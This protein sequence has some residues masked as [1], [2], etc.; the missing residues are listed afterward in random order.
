MPVGFNTVAVVDF[1]DK[2]LKLYEQHGD[3]DQ[4][5]GDVNHLTTLVELSR[6]SRGASTLAAGFACQPFSRLGDERG[7]SD[8]RAMCLRGILACAFYLQV[9]AVV[10]ECVQ[11]AALNSFVTSEI[12]AFQKATGFHCAQQIYHLQDVW[13]SRRSRAWWLLTSPMLGKISLDVWPKIPFVTTVRHVI[14]SIQPWDCDDEDDLAL[15]D[16]EK[17]AFGVGSNNVS[18]FMLNFESCAPCALHSWGSQMHAC[19]CGC[20]LAGLSEH[21]L[22]DKG[23]FG[24]LVHSC[25]TETKESLIRHVHPNEVMMLCGFDPIID[26]GSSTRLTLAAAGQMASPIQTA[27]VFATLEEKIQ[28]IRGFSPTFKAEAQLHAFLTWLVMRGRQVWPCPKESILDFNAVSL[29]RFWGQVSH[30]S[31]H[32][33]MHPNRWPDLAQPV[34]IA[35]VLDLLIRQQQAL[36]GLSLPLQSNVDVPMTIQDDEDE[37]YE[38]TPWFETP[39]TGDA[40]FA[41]L[42]DACVVVFHHSHVEP[43][44]IQVSADVTVSQLIHAHEK[45][46]GPFQV[47]EVR[48][49]AGSVLPQS[50]ILKEG[51]VLHIRCTEGL[52]PPCV[53]VPASANDC[54]P[55]GLADAGP[56]G[57]VEPESCVPAPD[58]QVPGQ[59]CVGMVSPT[60]MWTVPAHETPLKPPDMKESLVEV[61]DAASVIS[62]AP[63][64]ALT[65]QQLLKLRVPSVVVNKHLSALRSQ[66]LSAEDRKAIL[67]KQDG[68]WADDEMSHHIELLLQMYHDKSVAS[69]EVPQ[70]QYMMLDPLLLTGWV[71]YG[72]S[73]CHAWARSH[74]EV[75]TAQVTVLSACLLQGHWIPVVLS[76][77][78]ETLNFHTWDAPTHLHDPL[79]AVVE[80]LGKCLGFHRVDTLRQQR[81]F[82]STDKCGA[83]AVSFLHHT[84][85]HSML[86]S[87]ADEADMVHTK[88]RAVFLTFVERSDVQKRPWVW[89]TGEDDDEPF[90]NEPGQS[91]TSVAQAVPTAIATQSVSHQCMSKEDRLEL[92]RTKGKMWGDD[93]IRYHILIFC[94]C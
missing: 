79:V 36:S 76:P 56:V 9:Q 52:Q 14:P 30:L 43:L 45:L 4:V 55:C 50:L 29:I 64:L 8:S 58:V 23:L 17:T 82:F 60:A 13:V 53:P 44:Q 71:T 1:N 69:A 48:D 68:L 78:G 67:Q 26:F 28:Q 59:T 10:L 49:Q 19:Q 66:V 91:S 24:C 75:K 72:H 90:R 15:T 18:R 93:E 87:N 77:N 46:V 7:G 92:L 35:S 12:Q 74:P 20:R 81:I 54:A 83:I 25:P 2:F 21:R 27:W 31:M 33:L 3:A 11:P 34:T 32:E 5:V 65:G 51:Q 70:C 16:V 47:L 37:D 85:F 84:V 41:P 57:L 89:G 80:A 6:I 39:Q 22:K 73:W 40:L 88:L 38:P 63:L 86:P 42:N 62:A 61:S 94:I